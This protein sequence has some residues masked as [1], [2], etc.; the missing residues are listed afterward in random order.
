MSN[1]TRTRQT[2]V[3]HSI[4]KSTAT[5]YTSYLPLKMIIQ[6]LFIYETL[7]QFQACQCVNAKKLLE[8]I[9]VDPLAVIKQLSALQYIMTNIA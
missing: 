3:Q 8:T 7:L 2:E 9:E 5:N 1:K 6:K 4:D